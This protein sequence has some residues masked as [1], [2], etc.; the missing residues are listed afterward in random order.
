MFSPFILKNS[1][2]LTVKLCCII[3]QNPCVINRAS[4]YIIQELTILMVS[5]PDQHEQYHLD[6]CH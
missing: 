3:E 2:K 4:V 5:F 1:T 6:R